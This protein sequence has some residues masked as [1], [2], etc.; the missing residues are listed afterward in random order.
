MKKSLLIIFNFISSIALFTMLYKDCTNIHSQYGTIVIEFFTLLT[1]VYSV[2]R[3]NQSKNGHFQVLD[4]ITLY[5]T[6]LILLFIWFSKFVNHAWDFMWAINYQSMD[7]LYCVIIF[8]THFVN[9]YATEEQNM[10]N[11]DKIEA[12]L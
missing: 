11:L 3:V 1:C 7:L 6:N 12:D 10:Q 2:I 5:Y 8:I 4:M 9:F